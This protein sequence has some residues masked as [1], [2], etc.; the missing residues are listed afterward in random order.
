MGGSSVS[1]LELSPSQAGMSLGTGS[2]SPEGDSVEAFVQSPTKQLEPNLLSPPCDT[3]VITA[4]ALFGETTT[5]ITATPIFIRR[6]SSFMRAADLDTSSFLTSSADDSDE[7][8]VPNFHHAS[9]DPPPGVDHDS[10]ERWI[11]LNDGDGSHAPIAPIAVQRLA[12]FGFQTT[13]DMSMWA[14]DAKTDR[15]IKRGAGTG[16]KGGGG[17][18][19]WFQSTFQ[20][21]GCLSLGG[22]SSSSSSI[23]DVGVLI[24]Y[25]SF[26]HKYYG[27]ELPAIRSAGLVNMSAK[28]LME[29]MVDSARVKE[30]NKLSLG[31]TDVVT[32]STDMDQQGP[33]GKSI[34]K[35]MRSESKPPLVR[36]ILVFVSMLH[37]RELEDGSGYLIVTRAVHTP[38]DDGAAPPLKSSSN[39]LKSEIILGVNFIRKVDG[40]SDKCVMI[41]VNHIRSPMIPMMVAKRLGVA[42]AVNFLSDIKATC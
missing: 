41:N 32:F 2:L 9:V 37:A 25:G 6:K 19:C 33:F 5:T 35:V 13:C 22:S 24:W 40:Q 26:R 16:A 10:N 30:Y 18:P 36:K 8:S 27:H 17:A 29:L 42:S 34:T 7:A 4:K 11:A 23:G 31:R 14:P 20:S 12:I 28:A 1:P 3:T 38:Q 15:I 21:N 39:M